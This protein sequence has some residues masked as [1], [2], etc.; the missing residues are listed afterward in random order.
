[1]IGIL[2]MGLATPVVEQALLDKFILYSEYCAAAYCRPQQDK[3]GG[4]V[5][6][7]SA[8]TCPKVK[9]LGGCSCLPYPHMRISSNSSHQI[10]R[11]IACGMRKNFPWHI[12]KQR[13][14]IIAVGQP[15]SSLP[16]IPIKRLFWR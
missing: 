5:S 13:M 4:K 8:K 7:G 16:T 12:S 15:A 9:A 11:S 10:P 2:L 3:A 1:M 14:L 6:C